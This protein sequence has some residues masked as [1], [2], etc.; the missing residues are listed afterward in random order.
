MFDD[1]GRSC[2]SWSEAEISHSPVWKKTFGTMACCQLVP[3]M[4]TVIIYIYCVVLYPLC[5]PPTG[6]S[7][8]NVL[9]LCFPSISL[10]HSSLVSASACSVSSRT[11]VARTFPQ[12]RW[13]R[14]WICVR[15]R[16]VRVCRPSGSPVG[17]DALSLAMGMTHWCPRLGRFRWIV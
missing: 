8:N 10:S 2:G 4:C 9:C 17:D 11:A 1:L 7:Q 13:P 15:A 16:R 14:A 6:G 12:S 3:G 5:H